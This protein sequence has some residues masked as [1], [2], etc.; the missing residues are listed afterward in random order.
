L[1][2]H[3]LPHIVRALSVA[4]FTFQSVSLRGATFAGLVGLILMGL[5]HFILT[6]LLAIFALIAGFFAML[7][8]AI[9]G[10]F[11]SVF[12]S[13][14]R[15]HPGSRQRQPQAQPRARE[16]RS[17]DADVIDVDASEVSDRP[18]S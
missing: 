5:L 4:G 1:A 18:N 12:G 3:L 13:P 9:T 10:I 15:R 8:V 7:L 6:A 14:R 16:S 17:I 2:E 11:A